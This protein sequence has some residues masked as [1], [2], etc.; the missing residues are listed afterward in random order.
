ML[1]L[2]RIQNN[3]VMNVMRNLHWRC[4]LPQYLHLVCNMM[5]VCIETY[6]HQLL[7]L[8]NGIQNNKVMNVMKIRHGKTSARYESHAGDVGG[9]HGYATR[10]V[11]FNQ[12]GSIY[13]SDTN[14]FEHK[15]AEL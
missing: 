4:I 12:T 6:Q 13:S 5:K 11:T 10:V 1:L 15:A 3:K 14:L 7:P 9:L 8:L 2:N